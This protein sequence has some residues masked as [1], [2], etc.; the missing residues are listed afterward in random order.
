M[1]KKYQISLA[2]ILKQKKNLKDKL[3]NNEIGENNIL[4]IL[5]KMQEFDKLIQNYNEKLKMVSKNFK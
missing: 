4:D 3:E 2:L 1:E 5:N